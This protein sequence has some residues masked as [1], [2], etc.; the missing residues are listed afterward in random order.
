LTARFV[1]YK[2]AAMAQERLPPHKKP[3][4]ENWQL[5]WKYLNEHPEAG[6]PVREL[7]KAGCDPR[8]IVQ[9]VF[10]FVLNTGDPLNRQKHERGRAIKQALA[11]GIKGLERAIEAH[12]LLWETY[13]QPQD[14]A[15]FDSLHR[16]RAYL[17]ERLARC[18]KA[19]GVKRFGVAGS[20]SWLVMVQE[21]SHAAGKT[22]SW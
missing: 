6:D 13:Q 21:Y 12:R 2:L 9:Y 14:A 16:D 19:F 22:I 1:K 10:H 17:E 20:W 5:L 4:R 18:D 15:A 7:A 3:S 8:H 11:Q